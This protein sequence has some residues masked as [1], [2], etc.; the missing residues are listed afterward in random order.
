MV[1][2]GIPFYWSLLERNK[3]LTQNIDLL[4]FGRNAKLK[5][6]FQELYRSLFTKPEVYVEIIKALGTK[7][8]GMTRDEIISSAELDSGGKLTGYLED[9]ENCGFIR[10]Y[11]A[12]GSKTKNA[13]YQ[14]VDNFTLFYF[15]FM[16]GKNITD[17]NYWSKIQTAASQGDSFAGLR[18]L[19]E[20]GCLVAQ[21]L[22]IFLV[23]GIWSVGIFYL[24]EIYCFVTAVYQQ[25]NLC[26]GMFV[27]GSGAP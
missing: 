15:R 10:R 18:Q 23:N 26:S 12:I 11:Q 13:L 14:L 22:H 4:F 17:T 24:T 25:V 20:Q 3:S 6:E 2:G 16:D 7:K 19:P 9:L 1:F 27:S 21:V 8:V 5:D